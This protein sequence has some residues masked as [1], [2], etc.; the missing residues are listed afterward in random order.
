MER[1]FGALFGA[2]LCK[3]MLSDA[4]AKGRVLHLDVDNENSFLGIAAEFDQTITKKELY[5]LEENIAAKMNLRSVIIYP[6]YQEHLLTREY[7]PELV[8]ALRNKGKIVNGFLDD[9]EVEITDQCVS[10]NLCYGGLKILK[11]TGFDTALRQLIK[12]EFCVNREITFCGTTE[13]AEDYAAKISTFTA[14]EKAALSDSAAHPTKMQP[15]VG[16]KDS[17]RERSAPKRVERQNKEP[18]P[19][20]PFER[21][22]IVS[23]SAQV[24]I[25]KAIN[26]QPISLEEVNAESGKVVVWGDVLTNDKKETRDKAKY[27]YSIDFTDY[28][29]SNTLKLIC[30][31]AKDKEKVEKLDGLKKGTTI[32]IRGDAGFDKYDNE[33]NI[34]PL[35]IMTAQQVKKKDNAEN[36]RVELHCHTNMSSMDGMSSA[37]D[38]IMCAYKWGH[39]AIAITD[40]GVVQAY[41]EAMN[42]VKDI[43]KGGG[44]FKIIYGVEAYLVLDSLDVVQGDS[45]APLEDETVVFDLETTGFSPYNDRIIE[46]GAVKLKNGEIIDR[47]S[48]FVNPQ[49]PI[50]EKI[51]ELTSITDDMV[52]DAPLEEQ[53]VRDFYAF[54]GESPILV[55]HNASFDTGFL[56]ISL[57]RLDIT[58]NYT[59][60]DTVSIARALLPDLNNHKLD[61]VAKALKLDDFNHHR[62][63]DDAAVLASIY[64]KF[65]ETMKSQ[66]N[67]QAVNEINGGLVLDDYKKLPSY[68]QIILAKNQVGLKNLYKLISKSHFEHFYKKPRILKSELTRLREGLIL[69][70]ACEAGELYRA[71]VEQKSH[72]KLLDIAAY[73]D[74]L[75]IQP[76]TNNDFLIRSG[77]VKD[78][79]QLIEYN[80][81]IVSLA[82]QLGKP[83]VATG[84]VHYLNERDG[85]FRKILLS[86]QGYTDTEYQPPLHLRTTDEMLQEFSY[87]GEQKA[88]E[89][90]VEAPNHIADLID[91]SILPIPDGTYPPSIPGS[92]EDL[93]RITWKRVHEIYGEN[94]PEVVSARLERELTSII[95]HGFAVLYM[96]AQK[97]VFK[98]ESDGYLVG[99]RGSV[100]SSFVATMAGISEVNPLPPHY[101]CP[102]C[103]NSEFFLD[104]SVGSGFD[105][106][107]KNCPVC[108][109]RYKQDGH[110]IP[111]ETFLGFDGDKAPDIDLN[112]S[113]E[114]QSTAH[115]YTEE[116][117]GAD[118]VFK[119]GTIAT[120]ADKTAYGY[121]KNYL[122]EHGRVVH[123]AE[124]NR[125]V[126]GC[127]GVKRT[128]GQ[129]PGGMVVIPAGYDVTDFTPIQHP[130]DQKEKG[131]TTTHFDFHSLHDTILKLDILG[132]DVPTLYKHL[133]QLTGIKINDVPLNDPKV[134]SLFTSTEALGVEPKDIDCETGSLAIPE[135]G[136]D[137]V[138]GML[139]D[140]RPKN[141]SDLLQ[142]SGLSHGTDVWLGNAQEL[143]KNGTCTI[144]E[145]IGTRDSIMTYLIYKGVE[146]K[147]SF[148]IMEYTRKGKAPKEFTPELIQTLLDHNVPQWYIDS[149]LKIKYMF[150]KAH[151]A[152]YVIGAIRLGWFKVYY[153]LEFYAAFFTVRGG[154]FDAES[155]IAGKRVVM[156]KLA[157]LKVRKNERSAKEDGIFESL[158]IVNEML[159]R[160]LD[161]L[162]VSLYKSHATS[163]LCEDGKIRLPFCALKGVG[164]S[165]AQNLQAARGGEPFLSADDLAAK[166]G[167]SK[168]VI[169]ILDNAGA[170]EGLPKTS[171][172]TLF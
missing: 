139:L 70:T 146:K 27:I 103:K 120:V 12:D 138:R 42:T 84:D 1:T 33:V 62:A 5:L 61:T 20:N 45:T 82:E 129:H 83:C 22:P 154:D 40:H 11:Q 144:S 2:I 44:Q 113:G 119:A 29:G 126:S 99:S 109:T 34:R 63:C 85:V 111:F 112:F 57:K 170:L 8:T 137:F 87:L 65:I 80:K 51:T 36:K 3:D 166:A 106:P 31:K 169:E 98:S 108:G 79:A 93:Q 50:S 38:L 171:Q 105:L 164:E 21:L 60:V 17:D 127:V 149:C 6:R 23:G 155:A 48:T 58:C 128:T 13:I 124:E 131:I 110:D 54:C 114:Y 77:K 37:K 66:F 39:K 165:A 18:V 49:R 130:A 152:A 141:F 90:V 145:V 4:I 125:L 172:L 15:V 104:G 76:L 135:M 142:I 162:P 24:L 94:P 153:P 53:A 71:I 122:N 68:H 97:L 75:E 28:T 148:K 132:H 133:E 140:A 160:G 56:N 156:Q 55:A 92:E 100:G 89:V 73:Y 46:I 9:A 134:Y 67:I 10:V 81:L 30:D 102:N 150:P 121:V 107:E 16:A 136:T 95:K 52:K 64:L 19:G 151:A 161:F 96:I 159:A 25:G 157:D 32:I 78:E 123:K 41:P 7:F 26:Q 163:Y 115:R 101:V 47:F 158:Q 143:I 35:D 117:F 69:G 116:L 86:G 88:Y 14:A 74:F 43:R 91:D 147:L 118:N 72:Q 59:A 167:V 168:S